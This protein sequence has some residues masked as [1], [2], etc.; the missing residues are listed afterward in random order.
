[1]RDTAV[2]VG[3]EVHLPPG[4]AARVIAPDGSGSE[5]AADIFTATTMPGIYHTADGAF[6]FAVNPRPA[7]SEITPL[8]LANLRALGLPLDQLTP[9]AVN[10]S[11]LRAM[12]DEELERRQKWWWWLILGVV[13]VFIVE[14]ALAAWTTNR[15]M[16]AAT[17]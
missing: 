1:M 14:S 3:D 17:T 11:Q 15:R 4:A 5:A 7:E 2:W 10:E 8:S 13:G 12:A 6:A 16:A 9:A